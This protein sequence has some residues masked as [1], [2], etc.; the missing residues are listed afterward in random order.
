MLCA[1]VLSECGVLLPLCRTIDDPDRSPR[2]TGCDVYVQYTSTAVPV[3]R[4]VRYVY[5]CSLHCRAMQ[6][7]EDS[8]DVYSR[9]IDASFRPERGRFPGRGAQM[10]DPGIVLYYIVRA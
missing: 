6:R 4:A 3:R 8:E 7:I 1:P 2:A 5:A 9:P 10:H